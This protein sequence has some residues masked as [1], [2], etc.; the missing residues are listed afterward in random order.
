MYLDLSIRAG[1][2]LVSSFG[3]L[4]ELWRFRPFGTVKRRPMLKAPTEE[5]AELLHLGLLNWSQIFGEPTNVFV[6]YL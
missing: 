1:L 2:W 3:R 4:P 6:G 5:K